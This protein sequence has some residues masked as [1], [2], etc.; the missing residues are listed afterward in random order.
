MKVHKKRNWLG[1]HQAENREVEAEQLVLN[2]EMRQSRP[3]CYQMSQMR[4]KLTSNAARIPDGNTICFINVKKA[5]LMQVDSF[6]F[7]HPPDLEPSV[8]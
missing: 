8:W 3:N 7:P 2:L 6:F 5:T 1:F 4:S